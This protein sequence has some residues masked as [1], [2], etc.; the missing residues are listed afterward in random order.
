[1]E[2]EERKRI[3]TEI[4]KVH[5]ELVDA[6]RH[7]GQAEVAT[8]VLHNVGNVLNSVNTSAS[9]VTGLMRGIPGDGIGKVAGLLEEQGDALGEYLGRDNRA[10]SVI[11]YLKSLD[12]HLA[13]QQ[14]T[15]MSELRGLSQN[16]EHINQ[17]VAMQQSY[18]KVSG[19]IE[20][21]SLPAL[22]E[23][24]VRMNAAGFER[25]HVRIVREYEDLPDIPLDKHKVLQ[26]LVNLVSNAKHA[27]CTGSVEERVVVIGVHRNGDGFVRVSVSDSG[28]GIDPGNLTQIFAHGFTTRKDGHG[29][30]LHSG[31]LAAKEM[32]GSLRAESEGLGKGA[33]FILEL[34]CGP[35]EHPVEHAAEHAAVA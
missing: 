10:A 4:E 8:S 20:P 13:A 31:A 3:Q 6:S 32:G 27:L 11:N 15:I 22:I 29:F 35:G 34:P 1:M 19:A 21:Q 17:I 33:T 23:D 24:A 28:V 25:H 12:K 30:G 2:I 18:A 16:I 26:I 7:A 9:I 14:A 5:R